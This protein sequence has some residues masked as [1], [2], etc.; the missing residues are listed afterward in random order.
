[1]TISIANVY[2]RHLFK[3]EMFLR[4]TPHASTYLTAVCHKVRHD[5]YFQPRFHSLVEREPDRRD[6]WSRSVSLVLGPL[7]QRASQ[8]LAIAELWRR[9]NE[10]QPREQILSTARVWLRVARWMLAKLTEGEA[11]F[12]M[13]L[14]PCITG[15][16][17]TRRRKYPH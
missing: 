10:T 2:L 16:K 1:M 4:G 14:S 11:L 12:L 15:P 7:E 8:Y 17:L 3:L 6:S 9:S 5:N 13:F